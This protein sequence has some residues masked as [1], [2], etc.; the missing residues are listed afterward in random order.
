MSIPRSPLGQTGLTIPPIIF[1]TSCL[2]NLYQAVPD[3]TKLAILQE[4]FAH[5][6]VPVFLDSA[7]KYGAGLA[8]ETI[9]KGLRKL[10]IPPAQVIISNKLGWKRV[11]LKGP[12]PTFEPGAWVGLSHDAVQDISAEGILTAWRQGNAL[13]GS[14]YS[15]QIVSV[16]DPDEYLAAAPTALER[17]SRFKDIIAAYGA[18]SK[19]KAE[20]HV[21]AIGVG[22]KDWRVVRQIAD[23]VALDWVMLAVN[24]TIYSHPPELLRFVEALRA[25]GVAVINSAVFHAGFLVGGRYFDYR[26]PDPHSPTDQPMFEWRERFHRLCA[27]HAIQPAAACVQFALSPPGVVS[28]ALN[29]SA[30]ERVRENVNLAQT[31][32]P[33]E[34][35]QAAKS[36]QLIAGD[37]PYLG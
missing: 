12:E 15:A 9:G 33:N 11:P 7:G 19:L 10:K 25:R 26:I 29:T 16:H 23:C 4:F 2:G 24:L 21:R 28:I 13:L 6:D 17:K 34:F 32:I 8:L 36:E 5:V 14:D 27:Q 37:Y 35:W 20:G 30:P 18:L 1:G 31:T 3:E 22:S